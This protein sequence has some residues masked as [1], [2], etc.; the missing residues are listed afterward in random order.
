M[1]YDLVPG[2]DREIAHRSQGRAGIAASD[3]FCGETAVP[4]V[5][6]SKVV[7]VNRLAVHR[8]AEVDGDA[9]ID[10]H[11]DGV[12]GWTGGSHYGPCSR[13]TGHPYDYYKCRDRYLTDYILQYH[14][15]LFH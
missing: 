3:G 2:A 5:L 12:V 14:R 1:E 4:D 8:L 10:G 9:G 15:S 13:R 6:E 7:S 11:V